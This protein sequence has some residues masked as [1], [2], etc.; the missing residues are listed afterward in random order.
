MRVIQVLYSGLGGHGSVVSSLVLADSNSDWEHRLLFYGIEEL[1]PVYRQFCLD[2][3]VPFRYIKKKKGVFRFPGKEVYKVFKGTDPD[4]ILLH[5]PTLVLAAWLYCVLHRKKLFVAEHTPHATKGKAERMATLL[6]LLLASK[7][8]CLSE[9][10]RKEL[11]KRVP[12]LNLNKRTVVIRNGIDLKR[13]SPLPL[14][15]RQEFHIGMAGRFTAQKNQALILEVATTGLSTGL[16]DK[17]VHF[18]FA[19]NGPLLTAMQKYAIDNGISDQVH[20]HG[21]LE[22]TELIVFYCSLDLYIHMS[23]AETMCT[24]VMQAMACGIPIIGSDIP[25]INDLLP[26]DDNCIDLVPDHSV[27]TVI[28]SIEINL[29]QEYLTKK[30]SLSRLQAEKHFSSTKTF[31]DYFA[32]IS[33]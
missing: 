11:R 7:V 3:W 16:F 19:G 12:Y 1:L 28:R 23:H 13:F 4:V 20:F 26:A 30:R 5:S 32:L 17:N 10:Y 24:S 14:K 22:E 15:A 8:I 18:H 33:T 21:L 27:A 25:G 2:H 29:N 31:N 9:T 6:A